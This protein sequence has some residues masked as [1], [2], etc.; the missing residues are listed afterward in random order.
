[1]V[2]NL[3]CFVGGMLLSRYRETLKQRAYPGKAK[4]LLWGMLLLPVFYLPLPVLG[5]KL[6]FAGKFQVE[7][8]SY[9]PTA[10]CA[11]TLLIILFF[12]LADLRAAAPR[13]P[14]LTRVVRAT[15]WPGIL[16]FCLYVFHEPIL[17][18][19]RRLAPE[20][21][22]FASSLKYLLPSAILI[23]L[24]ATLCYYG[25]EEPFSRRKRTH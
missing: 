22:T 6:D 12:E 11:L 21:I 10:A 1:M 4:F 7:Y 24:A 19:M 14:I 5:S 23:T 2:F 20:S 16:T 18:A 9:A 25:V 17:L 13:H 3:D 8:S 15:H